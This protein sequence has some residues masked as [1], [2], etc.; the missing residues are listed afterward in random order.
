MAEGFKEKGVPPGSSGRARGDPRRPRIRVRRDARLRL[1]R[2]EARGGVERNGFA[3]LFSVVLGDRARQ[4]SVFFA[5]MFER[6]PHAGRRLHRRRHGRGRACREGDRRER[7]HLHA[8]V[9]TRERIL[10]ECGEFPLLTL[11]ETLEELV[12]HLPC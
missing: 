10:S 3:P 2:D 12:R 6:R 1:R 5:I 8:R 7:L 4:G 11:V 9:H